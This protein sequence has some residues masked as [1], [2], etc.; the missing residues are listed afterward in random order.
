MSATVPTPT[1]YLALACITWLVYD[2][3]ITL[4]D[5]VEFIWMRKWSFT[6]FIFLLMRWSTFGLLLTEVVVYVFLEDL[7]KDVRISHQ[8][9]TCP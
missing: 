6:K 4:D 1:G 7:S 2:Y 8:P 5:E 3:L 9:S